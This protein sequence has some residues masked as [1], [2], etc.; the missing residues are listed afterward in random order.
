LLFE[1][2]VL[3]DSMIRLGNI[4][5][6]VLFFLLSWLVFLPAVSH[7]YAQDDGIFVIEPPKLGLGAYCDLMEEKRDTP[8]SSTYDTNRKFRESVTLQSKGWIYHPDLTE[9][10]F[11]LE[12]EWQQEAFRRNQTTENPTHS[13][14]KNTSIWAYD[15][16]ATLLKRKPF[17]LNFFAN[18]KTGQIDFTNAQ[19]TDIESETL[20]TRGHL[21]NET[22]PISFALIHRKFDQSGF[23]QSEENRDEADLAM[24]HS[25]KQTDTRLNVHWN[26]SETTRTTFETT[27]VSSKT[28]NVELTNAYS[29]TDDNRIRLDSGI[30]KS[31]A[32]YNGLDQN[33]WLVTENLLWAH[34]KNLMGRY[35]ADYSRREFDGSVN[36]KTD[37]S[38]ALTH[39]YDDRLRTD[40]GAAATINQFDG[41]S[42]DI[43]QSNLGFLYHRPIPWGSVSVGAAYD[44]GLTNR[45]GTQRL[46]PT[47][48]E[49]ALT[50]GTDTYLD[51]ENVDLTS[52]VVTDITGTTVYTENIDYKIDTVG[53][54]VRISRTLL[55]AITD[56][57]QVIVHYGYRLDTAYDD[58]RF[59]QQYRMNLTL[60]SFVYLAYVHRRLDQD[61]LSGESPNDPLHD[62][63]NTVRLSFVSKWSDTQF[64]YD[65]ADRSNDNSIRTRRI[66]Q[67]IH[68]KPARNFLFNLS[69]S[70]GDRNF[71]DL[72]QIERF[73]SVG[74]SIGWTPKSWCNISL[75]CSRN[76]VSGGAIDER[77]TEI[78]ST[79]KLIYGIW[80]GSIS[81]R[82]RD[83]D[84]DQNDN[85]LWQQEMIIQITRHLW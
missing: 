18:R 63:T 71:T 41:G 76:I 82:L 5:T 10:H 28:M 64:L 42:E 45:S 32:E 20:G 50:T 48:S 67:R 8:N 26:R 43:Y 47:E 36:E 56:G 81:Y 44:Y 35:R 30:Y 7:L 46:I 68:F 72:D 57:Q 79:V 23:Y 12:P 19:D 80:T 11:S 39:H 75:L 16:G 65:Q 15:V 78:A 27:D 73:Y 53:S 74:S 54:L 85:R 59:G 69:G 22:L 60:W 17:S 24:R 37:L 3:I 62:T 6:A 70:I 52:I 55:G 49:F 84:D 13:Y 25:S 2:W 34:T 9:F 83:Q 66:T 33:T 21:N 29:I 14:D 61:I 40:L 38:A 58:S 51:K 77:D 1:R 4:R 31:Q